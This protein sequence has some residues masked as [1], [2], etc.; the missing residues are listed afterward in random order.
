MLRLLQDRT[1]RLSHLPSPK[2]ASRMTRQIEMITPT[3]AS[4]ELCRQMI[5][6]HLLQRHPN[7]K[8]LDKP[9]IK[10]NGVTK[11]T[12]VAFTE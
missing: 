11:L 10:D 1:Q 5:I 8:V 6:E 9:Q 4:D 2:S 3:T 12:T 7:A